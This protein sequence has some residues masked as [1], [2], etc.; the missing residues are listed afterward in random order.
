MA[1]PAQG[2]G[3]RSQTALALRVHS[4]QGRTRSLMSRLSASQWPAARLL[5]VGAAAVL[6]CAPRRGLGPNQ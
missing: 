2:R 3:L 5:R 6:A 1:A 4:R